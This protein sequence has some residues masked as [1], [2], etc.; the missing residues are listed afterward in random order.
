MAQAFETLRLLIDA[1]K[2]E[3]GHTI[4]SLARQPS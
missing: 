4:A 2:I 3:A 1:G